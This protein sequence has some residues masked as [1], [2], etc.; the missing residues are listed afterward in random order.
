LPLLNQTHSLSRTLSQTKSTRQ[1]A[2]AAV[3][4]AKHWRPP[5]RHTTATHDLS[6]TYRL[7]AHQWKIP[8]GRKELARGRKAD[9]CHKMIA[10]LPWRN[11]GPHSA[12]SLQN[13]SKSAR[14][15]RRAIVARRGVGR[16]HAVL[17]SMLCSKFHPLLGSHPRAPTSMRAHGSPGSHSML[18]QSHDICAHTQSHE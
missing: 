3:A 15:V 14:A 17:R 7:D 1:D 8:A 13:G 11:K 9:E 18:T 4:A 5:G 2:T 12:A 6:M 16:R 10:A